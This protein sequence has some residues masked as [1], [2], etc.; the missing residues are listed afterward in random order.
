MMPDGVSKLN[1][2]DAEWGGSCETAK[3]RHLGG[4]QTRRH[5]LERQI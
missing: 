1:F 3:R 4:G 5:K 2:G